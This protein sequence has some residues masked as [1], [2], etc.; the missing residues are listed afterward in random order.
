LI[1]RAARTKS[2]AASFFIMSDH[3][4]RFSFV[5][6]PAGDHEKIIFAFFRYVF[7]N[8]GVAESKRQPKNM[9]PAN[10]K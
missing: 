8:E 3:A 9:S 5:K 2:E 10:C 1:K 7:K 6:L 4:N